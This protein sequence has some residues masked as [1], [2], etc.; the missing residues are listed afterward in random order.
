MVDI[1][2]LH[3]IIVSYNTV[4][5]LRKCLKAIPAAVVDIPT[6]VSVVDNQSADGSA[7]M[8]SS[9]FPD[10]EL[11]ESGSNLGFAGGN[12]LILNR[13][14]AN[15]VL[16]LNPDTEATPGS[17]K[18]MLEFLRD[19]PEYGVCGPRLLN[20]DGSLQGNG[21]KF[22][23]VWRE[24]LGVSGLRRFNMAVFEGK[25]GFGRED[26]EVNCDVDEVSGACLMIRG[27]VLKQ[28]GPLDP[29]FFMFYEEIEFCHRVK[30]AGYKVYFLAEA[31]VTHHWMGS[32]KKVGKQMTAQ[33]FKSQLLYY[34]KT[35]G[36]LSVMAI[37]IIVLMGIT[38]NNIVHAGVAVKRVLR[39]VGVLKK[40]P[41]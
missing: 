17:L 40:R 23:T 7:G 26:L 27:D 29:R 3:I 25:H 38:K 8:V 34:Q 15:Y 24:F 4:D 18:L 22:P 12:N 39:N 33:L 13:S 2:D 21:R 36:P 41:V 14:T 35:S 11:V 5:L 20:S 1:P 37:R 19:H 9:E 16:L 28:I 30:A 6:F 31:I 10:V 32:V